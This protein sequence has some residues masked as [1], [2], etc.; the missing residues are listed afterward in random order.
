MPAKPTA[1]SAVP[2]NVVSLDAF[3]ALAAEK[4]GTHAFAVPDTEIVVKTKGLSMGERSR[5][6]RNARK[7]GEANGV[8]FMCWVVHY[9]MVE[10]AMTVEEISS[11][12]GSVIEPIYEDIMA[13]TLPPGEEGGDA[14]PLVESDASSPF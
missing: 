13:L 14:A 3:R 7:E 5:A 10:P 12:P 4:F 6:A 2:S 9:G 8:A 11:L 1:I